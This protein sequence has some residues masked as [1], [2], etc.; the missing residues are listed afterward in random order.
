MSHD[1]F[2]N[3]YLPYKTDFFIDK[4]TNIFVQPG[5]D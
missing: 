3:G 5:F 2:M 1:K 4:L